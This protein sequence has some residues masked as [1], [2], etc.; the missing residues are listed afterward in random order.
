MTRDRQFHV[1]EDARARI[2]D[3]SRKR[4]V[5]L[6]RV[7]FV[8][9]FVPSDFSLSVW[10]FYETNA[11]LARAQTGGGTKELTSAFM[12]ILRTIGYSDQWLPEVQFGFDSHENVEAN[13]EG[14]YF[15]RLR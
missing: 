6:H 15:Y 9:P 10:F 4:E 1:I 14:S 2:L 12:S 13:Y 11:Q 7:E 8:V 3:W 5:P